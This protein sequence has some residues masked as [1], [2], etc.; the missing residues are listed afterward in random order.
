MT[1]Q[2]H[3]Y[4]FILKIDNNK[5]Y[6]KIELFPARACNVFQMLLS[7]ISF[8]IGVKPLNK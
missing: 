6:N 7:V 8:H 3:N 5:I 4:F 2:K 1:L